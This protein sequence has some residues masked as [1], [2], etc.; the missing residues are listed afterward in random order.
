MANGADKVWTVPRRNRIMGVAFSHR[1]RKFKEALMT[2]AEI[3]PDFAHWVVRQLS[4]PGDHPVRVDML[5]RTQ[6]LPPPGVEG[7]GQV[8]LETLYSENLTVDR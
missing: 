8:G 7:R 4:G 1:W 3:R 2:N 6:Q 5:L